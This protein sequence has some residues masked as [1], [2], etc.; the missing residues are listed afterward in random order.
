MQLP[1]KIS[2]FERTTA[3]LA[4]T[5]DQM[6]TERDKLSKD[7]LLLLE[8]KT[9]FENGIDEIKR[10]IVNIQKTVAESVQEEVKKRADI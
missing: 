5:Q 8:E 10:T 1:T 4:N 2:Q 9:K 6:K 3:A 7:A